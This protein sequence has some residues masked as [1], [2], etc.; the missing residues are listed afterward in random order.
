VQVPE[1][2]GE[3]GS[4][5]L[6]AVLGVPPGDFDAVCECFGTSCRPQNGALCNMHSLEESRM[7]M[8]MAAMDVANRAPNALKTSGVCQQTSYL[9][10]A[11]SIE[12]VRDV[13]RTVCKLSGAIKR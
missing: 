10:I 6:A 1:R 2:A 11:R 12:S 9:V 3:S 7:F 4:Q 13:S 8:C 5:E